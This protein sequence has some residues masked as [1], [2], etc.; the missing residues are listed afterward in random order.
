[1]ANP[2]N[3]S[4]GALKRQPE[5]LNFLSGLKYKFVIHKTPVINFFCQKCTLPGISIDTVEQPT[6]LQ[7][8]PMAGTT[9]NYEDLVIEFAVDENFQ[10][11]IEIWKWINGLG[12]PKNF[13][14]YADLKNEDND[15]SQEFGGLYA[16]ATLH[17]LSNETNP[18]INVYFRD[19][20]PYSL[21]DLS[22]DATTEDANWLTATARFKYGWV[23]IE[24]VR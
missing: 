13:H 17:I 19:A 16:D 24:A 18:I 5:N 21:S 23:D 7:N 20:F 11:Y 12:F 2:T 14:E 6:P 15:I 1:M 9:L 8:L 22:F 3:D 10:S 4:I